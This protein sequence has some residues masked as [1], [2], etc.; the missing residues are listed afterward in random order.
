MKKVILT[1]VIL[2]F[3]C[4]A[5]AQFGRILDSA[6]KAKRLSDIK[7]SD[8]EERQIG[9]QVSDKLVSE[10]GVYQNPGVA[11]YVSLV[12][13]VMAQASARPSLEWQ[14]IVLD[15]D[16][17]N[18]FAAPG[19]FI[20]VTRGLLGLVKNEAELA[21]VLGHEITHAAKKHT[22]NSIQKN[23]YIKFGSE[24][25]NQGGGLTQGLISRFAERAYLSVLNNEFDRGDETESDEEGVQLANKVGYAPTGLSS[26]L[27]KLADRNKDRKEPNGLFASHPV[28]KDR[29]T[30]IAKTIRDKKLTATATADARY[31]QNIKFD[32]KPMAEL[33]VVPPD[34]RGLTGGEPNKDANAS[35]GDK[36]D[37]KKEEKKSGGGLGG[38]LG[39]MGLSG[40][41]QAQSSQTVASAGARGGWPDRDAVGGSNKSKVPVTISASEY[42][43]FKKGIA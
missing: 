36:K 34:A 25:V 4:P 6:Q 3:A 42:A 16:G 43:E 20:H 19:G 15:T 33:A 10:F 38:A 8:A 13:G 23:S 37:E 24:E 30:N 18:A 39:K 1:C 27:T 11:K 21:G 22:I 40:K 28:I 9:Q 32:A 35:E 12:G 2:L 17:V 7:I 41:S 26:V 14:F 31:A 29:L 5:F